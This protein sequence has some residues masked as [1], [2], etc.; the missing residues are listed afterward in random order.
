MTQNNF[1][2]T[3]WDAR[4]WSSV[5]KVAWQTRMFEL[6]YFW[7]TQG[8]HATN[9]HAHFY[10]ITSEGALLYGTPY[11]YDT[12]K[13]AE[14]ELFSY[15]DAF[16]EKPGANNGYIVWSPSARTNPK[17][18]HKS[19]ADAEVECERLTLKTKETFYVA[20]LSAPCKIQYDVKWGEDN[21]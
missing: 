12:F 11:S 7:R 5:D 9:L 8:K 3:K 14:E 17:V 6:G 21:G 16:T 15:E 19:Y 13:D 1:R 20:T 2:G 18:V 4:A 10:Y